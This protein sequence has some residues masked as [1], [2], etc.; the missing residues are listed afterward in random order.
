MSNNMILPK[1][2]KNFSK[3]MYSLKEKKILEKEDYR[4]I[5]PLSKVI[6]I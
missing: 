3:N 6:F 5:A 4:N 2:F 1:L